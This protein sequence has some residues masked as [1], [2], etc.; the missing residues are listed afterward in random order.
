MEKCLDTSQVNA[1]NSI[2]TD[3]GKY[4]IEIESNGLVKDSPVLTECFGNID[5]IYSVG[6]IV[7][8][9]PITNLDKIM[10]PIG[11]DLI[12]ELIL[13]WFV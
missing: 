4:E 5:Q 7:Y 8:F 3:P 13:P 2:K 1:K 6:D 11:R 12:L 9:S 10:L